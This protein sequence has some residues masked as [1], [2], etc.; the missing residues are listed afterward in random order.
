M[1]GA[2]DAAA[3]VSKRFLIKSR[4]DDIVDSLPAVFLSPLRIVFVQKFRWF[5]RVPCITSSSF[6][7]NRGDF[8]FDDPI[9][10]DKHWPIGIQLVEARPQGR[11]AGIIDH[12]AIETVRLR[13]IFLFNPTNTV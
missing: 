9:A 10:S 2:N 5:L 3:P 12:D 8:V 7:L 11:G 6:M 1:A 4:R 13:R